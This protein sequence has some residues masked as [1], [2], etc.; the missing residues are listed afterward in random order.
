MAEGTPQ[1]NSVIILDKLIKIKLSLD[2]KN[3]KFIGE[4]EWLINILH[5]C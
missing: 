4:E 3:L 1:K 2:K 5:Q